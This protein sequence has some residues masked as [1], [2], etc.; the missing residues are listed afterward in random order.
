M[1]QVFDVTQ[2][3]LETLQ[4]TLEELFGEYISNCWNQW[5]QWNPSTICN[6]IEHKSNGAQK[7]KREK[8]RIEEESL[9]KIS[10]KSKDH[11]QCLSLNGNR[12]THTYVS[13]K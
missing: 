5:N 10:S 7:K 9:R 2:N 4:F 13:S 8:E 12:I 3:K 1:G 11:C 6:I